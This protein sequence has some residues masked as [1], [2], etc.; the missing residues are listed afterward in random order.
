V[1]VTRSASTAQPLP[2]RE[3]RDRSLAMAMAAIEDTLAHGDLGGA[4]RA[5]GVA[6][7]VFGD[8]EPLQSALQRLETLRQQHRQAR[9]QAM[10]ATIRQLADDGALGRAIN[11]TLEA[12]VDWPEDRE[13]ETLLQEL[14]R[15][16]A[17]MVVM[18]ALARGDFPGADRALVLAEQRFG[19]DDDLTELRWRVDALLAER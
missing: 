11:E 2:A 14:R 5:L 13:L 10:S 4:E 7:R 15:R 6:F 12:L 1:V 18:D 9:V 19:S 17:A 3:H 16:E 8:A